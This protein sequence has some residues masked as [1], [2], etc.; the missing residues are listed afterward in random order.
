MRHANLV[1][2][3]NR[4]KFRHTVTSR[5]VKQTV[6]NGV[7]VPH[8][9]VGMDFLI[10]LRYSN[11]ICMYSIDMNV[12]WSHNYFRSNFIWSANGKSRLHFYKIDTE[13]LDKKQS[14]NTHKSSLRLIVFLENLDYSSF[15]IL[16]LLTFWI[17]YK[18]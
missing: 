10:S 13:S 6:L 3:D 5:L 12:T 1:K 14:Y 7:L 11:N 18:I 9:V 16:Y 17:R 8:Y 15:L 2:T 4:L